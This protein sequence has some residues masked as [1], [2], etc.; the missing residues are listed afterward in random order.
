[1]DGAY[2][3]LLEAIKILG[4][5]KRLFVIPAFE[6]HLYRFTYPTNKNEVLNL[7]K[8]GSVS[9]FRSHEWK[10]GHAPT[11]YKHWAKTGTPYKIK[12]VDDYE[13]YVVVQSN[14]TKY[15]ERFAGFGWNKV[16]HMMELNAQGY[17]FVVLPSVFMIHM[18]HSPSPDINL[19]RKSKLYRD[20]VQVIK[21]EFKQEI[22]RQ[23]TGGCQE[24][25]L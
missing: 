16:S 1:M 21:T 23:N 10:R 7:L 20:C 19:F 8:N 3:Y 17:E 13:P 9:T 5:P 14:V 6:T 12:W 2:E 4:K 18:P 11:N 15:D 22:D 24:C 25:N